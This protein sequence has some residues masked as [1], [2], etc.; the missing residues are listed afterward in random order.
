MTQQDIP[1]VQ[2]TRDGP[3]DVSAIDT[4]E[5]LSGYARGCVACPL[6]RRATQTVFGQGP[7]NASIMVVGEQP[8][9]EEDKRGEP[10]VGASGRLLDEALEQAGLDR[11]EV[12]IT[13]AVKHFKWK[14][15]GN[16]RLNQNPTSSEIA[17][18]YPWLQAEMRLVAPQIVVCLGVTASQAI[19]QNRLTLRDLGATPQIAPHGGAAIATFHP[20]AILRLPDR[21][22]RVKAFQGLVRVFSI[23]R[24][25][26]ST[27]NLSEYGK[28]F[29]TLP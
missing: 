17:A 3:L 14:S 27:D 11:G 2:R 23:A 22:Q 29:T 10:F 28:D 16:R 4:M 26:V 6:Y 9:D 8:G 21:D 25:Y 18:C 12:Y 5:V 15:N 24:G 1:P 7:E 13:N 20:S 19:F